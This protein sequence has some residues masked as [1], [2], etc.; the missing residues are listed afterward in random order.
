MGGGWFYFI[1]RRMEFI[2]INI[3]AISN[4]TVKCYFISAKVKR[5]IIVIS[6]NI[7]FISI[8]ILYLNFYLKI[9]FYIVYTPVDKF[10]SKNNYI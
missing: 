2:S 1:F 8:I 10:C 5:P 4:S 9:K 6:K 7:G 3:I